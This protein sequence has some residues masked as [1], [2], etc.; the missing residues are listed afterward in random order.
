M[1]GRTLQSVTNGPPFT[2]G[3]AIDMTRTRSL[4]NG[5]RALLAV[6]ALAAVALVAVGSST[7]A[8]TSRPASRATTLTSHAATA[9]KACEVTDTGGINDRSFN[10]SAYQ[11][12]KVAAAAVPGLTYTFLSSTS[13]SDYVPNINDFLA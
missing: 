9:F 8:T 7:G 6:T 4:R 10:A 2:K 3:V 12:L 13:T 5:I 11:G 1:G